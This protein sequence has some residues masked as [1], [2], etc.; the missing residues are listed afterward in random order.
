M[1]RDRE[2]ARN[3][4]VRAA[5]PVAEPRPGHHQHAGV[6]II[7]SR[8]HRRGCHRGS[9][10]IAREVGHCHGRIG[11]RRP[12]LGRSQVVGGASGRATA[13]LVDDLVDTGFVSG[14]ERQRKTGAAG[15][16]HIAGV[17][18]RV[19]AATLTGQ[20]ELVGNN[21]VGGAI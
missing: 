19:G 7:R 14:T 3:D 15:D 6:C 1:S 5:R 21:I 2:R 4:V 13:V 8:R 10:A 17:G 16:L 18:Q 12:V 9:N 11:T 20:R